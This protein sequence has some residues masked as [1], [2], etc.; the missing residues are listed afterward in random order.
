MVPEGPDRKP[1][2]LE[3][4]KALR[5]EPVTKKYDRDLTDRAM[6]SPVFLEAKLWERGWP[7]C[8]AA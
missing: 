7:S 4:I 1:P 3:E 8:G 5:H 6:F 2:P